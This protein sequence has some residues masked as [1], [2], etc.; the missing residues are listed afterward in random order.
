MI[1]KYKLYS[2]A[3]LLFISCFS[4]HAQNQLS[5]SD[6]VKTAVNLKIDGKPADWNPA[7][8]MHNSSTDVDY[9]VTNDD[10]NFYLMIQSKD[11]V[12]NKKLFGGGV[13]LT[14]NSTGKFGGVDFVS[15][16]YP[17]LSDRSQTVI[18]QL[19]N[20][21]APEGNQQGKKTFA[22]SI[23][24]LMNKTLVESAKEIQVVGIKDISDVLISVY[25][26][27]G[28][29]AA[30]Q[31]QD[32]KT[33]T[34]EIA[35]PLK[36]FTTITVNSNKLFYNIKL[37]GISNTRNTV[38]H[39]TSDGPVTVTTVPHGLLNSSLSNSGF[40]IMSSATDFW[41]EYIIKQ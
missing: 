23:L 41:S 28:I 29:K 21:E 26:E 34:Y 35:I 15:V 20:E 38:V 10:N 3:L 31:F 39:Q 24:S 2:I 33:L 32:K 14:L 4:L 17:T 16:K 1:T 8:R 37:N 30:M 27:Y 13:T 36:Y 19:I 6:K 25:N 40:Q 7:L 11:G 12:I 9:Y 5:Q 18:S 22:D